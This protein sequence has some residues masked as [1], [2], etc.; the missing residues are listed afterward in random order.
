MALDV[1]HAISDRHRSIQHDLDCITYQGAQHLIFSLPRD[2][3]CLIVLELTHNH[4]PLSSID[5]QQ[6]AAHSLSGNLYGTLIHAMQQRLGLNMAAKKL[7]ARL[8]S[9][10]DEGI[11]QL[12]IQTLRWCATTM[13]RISLDLEELETTRSESYEPEA[14]LKE[15]FAVV[16]EAI[17]RYALDKCFF[18][19]HVL[20][21]HG[22][23][24]IATREVTADWKDLPRLSEHIDNHVKHRIQR[25]KEFDDGLS[26]MFF[27]T[28]RHEEGIVLSQLIAVEQSGGYSN[29]IGLALFYAI[30]SG[31]GGLKDHK[32][33][34]EHPMAQ[35]SRFYTERIN[36]E[37]TS[38]YGKDEPQTEIGWFL[39]NYGNMRASHRQDK[40]FC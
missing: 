3:Y 29:V 7:R 22:D 38:N 37:A 15:A 6:A 35:L 32:A 5:G 2:E 18:M 25:R 1:P 26:Q 27:A 19:F 33:G 39:H 36:Q 21:Y 16:D 8:D 20:R 24:L 23:D 17:Q 10:Q 34:E 4:R 40:I 30:M 9:N 31:S 12:V 13:W 28:G 11:E 14:E